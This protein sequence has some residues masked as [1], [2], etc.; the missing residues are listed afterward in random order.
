MS[1]NLIIDQMRAAGSVGIWPSALA[2]SLDSSHSID[3][4][5]QQLAPIQ[6][7]NRL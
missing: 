2:Y 5:N 6:D 7:S 4:L 3:L 1:Q